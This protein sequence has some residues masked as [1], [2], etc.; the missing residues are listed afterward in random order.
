MLDAAGVQRAHLVG[1]DWGAALAWAVALGHPERVR[2]L[3]ALAVGHPTAYGSG[4]RDQMLRSLYILAFLVEGVGEA[5]VA[6]EDYAL[7]TRM[8]HPDAPALPAALA[9]GQLR[10]HCNWYRANWRPDAFVAPP[11]RPSPLTVPALGIWA[12]GDRAHRGADDRLGPVLRGGLHL[13][14]PRGPRALVRARGAGSCDQSPGG[15]RG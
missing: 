12:S 5:F 1:H 3:S 14:A 11:P 15:L 8:G 9:A 7:L 6:L 10:A 2:T 13:R 4:G